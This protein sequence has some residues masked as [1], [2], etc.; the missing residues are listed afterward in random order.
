MVQEIVDPHWLGLLFFAA[1][2]TIKAT[3][4]LTLAAV[5]I[6]SWRR[7]SAAS[8]HAVWSMALCSLALLPF[9]NLALPAWSFAIP[10]TGL[11]SPAA[12]SAQPATPLPP[13]LA[14]LPEAV[15]DRPPA[16]LPSTRTEGLKPVPLGPV[17]A[18]AP[19]GQAA[20]PNAPPTATLP[21]DPAAN[22]ALDGAW[23]CALSRILLVV[24]FGG[25]LMLSCWLGLALL[26]LRELRKSSAPV[27]P[28]PLSDLLREMCTTLGL[29]RPVELCLTQERS[30]PMTWGGLQPV[31]LL[32][33][34][35]QDWPVSRLRM[36]L[37]H[38]LAH[39]RRCDSLTQLLAYLVRTAYWFH[40]LAWWAA[41]RMRLEQ[42]RACDDAVLGTGTRASDYAEQ[43]LTLATALRPNFLAA[44]VALAVSRRG[45]LRRRVVAVLNESVN[46]RP[47]RRPILLGTAL[48]VVALCLALAPLGLRAAG[49]TDQP[50]AKAQKD[51]DKPAA[52][53]KK[54]GEVYNTLAKKYVKKMDEKKVLAGA[55]KGMLSGLD[56]PYADYYDA[57]TLARFEKEMGG[58]LAGIGIQIKLDKDQ[59]KI[60]T[61]LENSPALKAGL[62]AGDIILAIDGKS[63]KGMSLEDCVKKILG[64]VGAAVKL[65]VQQ[66]NAKK[67]FTITRALIQMSSLIG[68]RRDAKGD[69]QFMLDPDNK[70]GYLHI[71]Q[72]NS[73]AADQI[74]PAIKNLE[75]QGLKG[76]ILDLRNC[77]G[78]MLDQAVAV[79]DLFLSDGTILTIKDHDKKETVFKAKKGNDVGDFPVLVLINQHTASSAE[80]VAGALQD[81]KRAVLLGSRT[82]G[83]GSV[84][85]ILPLKDGGA[86]KLT[87]AW[88]YLPSGRN[89]Q[90]K[91]GA[92]SWGV[93]PDNGFFMPLT[94]EQ[95]AALQD[96]ARERYVLGGKAPP[97]EKITPAVLEK[98]H[99]DPQLAAAL[100]TM[101]ARVTTGKF[102]PVGKTVDALKFQLKQLEDLQKQQQSV[103]DQLQ[104]IQQQLMELE[105]IL[106][107][108]KK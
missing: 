12:P 2:V 27:G 43:L 38:E 108:E 28:G 31:I 95:T 23:L 81:N 89:I 19:T 4:V 42:E 67:D 48:A 29:R 105:S 17:Q 47:V 55:V 56:D 68:F 69:W 82:F 72:F 10:V 98:D 64:P 32:P 99:A 3:V 37:T 6:W 35:A 52:F 59:L 54:L 90:K 50:P 86:L 44:P 80:I 93:D 16:A 58:Q 57:E 106:G 63:T 73:K 7:S 30:M 97:A 45:R 77:P 34:D 40:P 102:T 53:E 15:S 103:Q 74:G 39:V 51:D 25:V 22:F 65:T 94:K 85:S 60:V 91:P 87:T 41:S 79:A 33:H 21:V 46:R 92:K 36:V 84:A 83:K 107:K 70:I 9:L 1:D 13:E 75:K 5:V 104:Q 26:T 20:L 101:I 100:K 14:Q 71:Q 61:P 24:W 62:R 96:K 76:L 66:E 8:R 49:V 78:G 88:H 18:P 11:V